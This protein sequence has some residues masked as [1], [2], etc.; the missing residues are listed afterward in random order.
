MKIYFK[1]IYDFSEFLA[2]ADLFRKFAKNIFVEV[3]KGCK[4]KADHAVNSQ[5]ADR[6]SLR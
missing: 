2:L 6:V 5:A 1:R 4:S 3:G